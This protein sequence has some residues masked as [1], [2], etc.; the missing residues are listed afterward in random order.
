MNDREIREL[1]EQQLDSG[2]KAKK[3]DPKYWITNHGRVFS[4]APCTRALGPVREMKLR[5]NKQGY[6]ALSL[7]VD[8]VKVV[9]MVHRLVA[10]AFLPEAPA[11][12]DFVCHRNGNILD[13]N[14]RNLYWADPKDH[15]FS[16]ILHGHT[17]IGSRSG[18]SKLTEPD[19]ARIKG[20]VARGTKQRAICRHFKMTKATISAIVNEHTW[21]HVEADANPQPLE[22]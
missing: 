2:C 4:T 5:V 17:T 3:F 21:R 19:V 12:K 13:N 10:K 15:G 9:C 22:A 6:L 1:I 20:L 14:P 8:E 7:Q 11:G 18:M 16:N